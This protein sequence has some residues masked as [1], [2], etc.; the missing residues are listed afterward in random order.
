MH[1]VLA[2]PRPVFQFKPIMVPPGFVFDD[3]MKILEP[4]YSSESLIAFHFTTILTVRIF[5]DA[6]E[7]E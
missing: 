4:F 5:L 3:A 7:F 1:S 6:D 2:T